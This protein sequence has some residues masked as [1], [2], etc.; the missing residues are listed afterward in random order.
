MMSL[1]FRIGHG[2][3]IH[4][5]VTGRLLILGGVH[6][7]SEYG[8][9]GHSD[10]DCLTHALADAILGGLGLSDIGH[11][12]PNTDHSIKGIDS[13]LI[14]KKA[15]DEALRLGYEV[16]NIDISLIAE[17]PKL[18]PYVESMR[19]VLAKTLKIESDQIGIKATTKEGH[20]A[21]GRKQAIEA[22]AV[23][24]LRKI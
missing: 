23:V 2:Y 11:Y 7:P 3:D 19:Q 10:A 5:L 21:V 24:L 15:N 9:D 22:H 8:L 13:Q 17:V 14:L 12:F 18:A 4:S 20:D 1:L 6:I 16:N